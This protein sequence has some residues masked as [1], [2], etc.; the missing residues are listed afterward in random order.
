MLLQPETDMKVS[1]SNDA[2]LRVRGLLLFTLTADVNN[3][4]PKPW[5]VFEMIARRVTA[6]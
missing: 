2:N 4:G 6:P 3:L 1:V 5:G